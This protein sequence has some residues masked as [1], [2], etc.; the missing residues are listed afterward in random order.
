[1]FEVVRYVTES[2]TDVFGE[3]LANLRDPRAAAKIVVRIDRLAAG[4]P[5][6]S[7]KLQGG[8][9]ELRIDWGP[10]Y[11]VYFARVGRRL[12]LLLCGGDKKSQAADIEKAIE[13]L[14]DY[15]RRTNTQDKGS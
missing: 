4:N 5:G 12:L 6:D 2:G 3:L 10:G 15:R 14:N 1:M 9:S 13:Y 8:L 11:R 7:K